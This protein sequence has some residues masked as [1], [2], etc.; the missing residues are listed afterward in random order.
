M[1]EPFLEQAIEWEAAARPLVVECAKFPAPPFM[2]GVTKVT[3]ARD[4][5]LQLTLVAEG[6]LKDSPELGRRREE[7]DAIPLGAFYPAVET[8]FDAY[9]AR[10]DLKMHLEHVPSSLVMTGRE[11]RFTQ[12]GS[13][14]RLRRTWANKLVLGINELPDSEALLAPA[15]MSDWYING[16][17]H[18]RF[19]NR[20]TRRRATSFARE[21]KF[22]TVD[23][24]GGGG[25]GGAWDHIVVDAPGLRFALS[26][27]PEEHAAG[28]LRAV[29]LD[30]L[31]PFPDLETRSALGEIVSFVL[32]RRMM[33]VGSTTF[34]PTGS[35]I[36]EE[37]VNP[38]GSNIRTLCRS[39]DHPP[40]PFHYDGAALELLLVDLVPRYLAAREPLGLSD[41]LWSYWIAKESPASIDLPIFAAAVEALKRNWFSS[42]RSKSKGLHMSKDAFDAITGDLIA[43]LQK[44]LQ[45]KGAA[46]EIGRTLA[47]ANRM[48]F[49]VQLRAFFDEIKLTVGKREKAALDARHRSAHGAGAE[50]ELE[51]L[52]RFGNA[53]RTLFDR[54]F[55]RL[56]GYEGRYVD[57]TTEGHP[58]RDLSDAAGGS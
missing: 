18:I 37:S 5:N 45:E 35:V 19:T 7:Q 1:S 6:V 38:W 52:A 27:V 10:L 4:D 56:L 25:L 39:A 34:D 47:G 13:P 15:W 21:R 11:S 9:G 24:P 26:Q 48:G 30:F 51:N 22:Q 54:V 3:I 12:R 50:E 36:E 43:E 17:T 46:D 31:A 33:R 49:T 53:Y 58:L 28:D 57:R 2:P 32:G 42:T 23:L 16:A 8:S 41:A 44:R 40:V 14:F 29:S 55:L 20:T